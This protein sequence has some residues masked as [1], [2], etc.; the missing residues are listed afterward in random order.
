MM[1]RLEVKI[2]ASYIFKAISITILSVL[3]II[4]FKKLF[5]MKK[6]SDVTILDVHI[7]TVAIAF[8]TALWLAVYLK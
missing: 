3:L 8:E 1:K 2:V 5:E 6:Q 7:Q 4:S